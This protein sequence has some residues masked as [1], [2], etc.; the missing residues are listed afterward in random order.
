MLPLYERIEDDAAPLVDESHAQID[1]FDR[2]LRKGAL[3]EAA[4]RVERISTNGA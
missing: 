3:V 4:A 2:R 1:V